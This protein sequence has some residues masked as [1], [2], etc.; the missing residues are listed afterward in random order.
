MRDAVLSAPDHPA[1]AVL[2]RAR[3]EALLATPAPAL[4]AMSRAYVLRLASVF[5]GFPAGPAA[6]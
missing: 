6:Q 4:D 3:V 2:D 5:A 1:W